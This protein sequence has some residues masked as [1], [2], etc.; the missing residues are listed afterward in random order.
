MFYQAG[1]QPDTG[2]A[3]VEAIQGALGQRV[4]LYP[5]DDL[6]AT[7]QMDRD[8]IADVLNSLCNDANGLWP[9]LPAELTKPNITVLDVCEA[10]QRL[11]RPARLEN[12]G[13]KRSCRD[14]I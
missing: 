13:F 6:E 8:E 11:S 12:L 9:G 14:T 10:V 3:V 2:S 4:V 7:L 5:L 1:I